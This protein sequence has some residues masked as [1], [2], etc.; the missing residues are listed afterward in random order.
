ML[1][2]SFLS[3]AA[4][5]LL[6][7]AARRPNV[8]FLAADDLNNSLG[9][10]GHG[11][12]KSPNIDKLAFSGV[13]FERAYCQFPLCGPSRASLLTGMRPDR[14]QVLGNNVDFREFHPHAVTLPQLFK[15][16]GWYSARE[17]KMYHMNVPGEVGSPKYQD[18]AS[19]NHSVSPPGL[20]DK[21]TGE[22]GR[23]TPPG[24]GFGM[25][26]ISTADAKGQ[27]DDNAAEHAIG[28][29]EQHRSQPFFLGVGFVRPHLPFVAPSRYYDLYPVDSIPAPQNPPGDLD[30]IPELA[31]KVRPQLWNHMGMDERQQRM[32]RRGYYASTS[33]MD[34]QTGRVLDALDKMG[35]RDNTIVVFWGD[36][37]WNLGEHTRWQKMSLMEGSARVPL[38][39][40][41]PGA[42]GNGRKARG[43]T[44]FVDVY[45]TLAE[46]C[47][48]N[49]PSTTQGRSLAPLLQDPAK[50]GKAAAY[51]QLLFESIE[52]RSVRTD[53]FRYIRWKDLKSGDTGEEL[54]DHRRDPGEFTNLAR[55][56]DHFKILQEHRGLLSA[57]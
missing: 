41:A 13:L 39:I 3:A 16:N 1:R 49:T 23:L 18:E 27:A 28:L 10:Y 5:P 33:F 57:G 53:H 17:G 43:L 56:S 19:W 14:S 31:R 9:C 30:D 20:E 55:G 11:V 15:N 45:P 8:L 54:Y 32:A 26:W 12:V 51:T 4:S 22:G 52:G 6:A 50:T 48:L 46:L 24:R 42:R 34:A 47:G 36:H 21:S 2:R 40:R 25:Q 37:G 7:R 35:L 44:E 38:I 29:L